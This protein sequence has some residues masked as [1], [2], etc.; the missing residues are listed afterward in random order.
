MENEKIRKN[1]ILTLEERSRL[2]VS[3]VENIES[4]SDEEIVLKTETGRLQ[5]GGK[6]LKLE[7]LS[8]ENGN[9]ALTGRID[10]MRFTQTKEKQSLLAGLFK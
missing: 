8:V 4:F 7:D 6:G 10:L 5:I 1:Q 3:A 9:A 2:S